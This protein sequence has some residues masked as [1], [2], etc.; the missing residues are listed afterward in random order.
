MDDPSFVRVFQSVGDLFGDGQ[1]IF[2]RNRLPADPL[3]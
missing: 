3:S 1:G 2:K